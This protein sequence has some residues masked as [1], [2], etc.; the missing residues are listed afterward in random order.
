MFRGSIKGDRAKRL[1]AGPAVIGGD[2][3]RF[4]ERAK[5][6]RGRN[7]FEKVRCVGIASA[8]LCE[9]SSSRVAKIG[10]RETL[11]SFRI[12]R[13]SMGGIASTFGISAKPI[14]RVDCVC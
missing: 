8:E 3:N 9:R 7:F 1:R 6:G 14:E 11:D 12:K 2:G 5:G 4:V 13:A 10:L